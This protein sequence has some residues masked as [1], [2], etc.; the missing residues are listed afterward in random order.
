[1]ILSLIFV[2]RISELLLNS[3]EGQNGQFS[4]TSSGKTPGSIPRSSRILL[5]K[6]HWI[7]RGDVVE[8]GLLLDC[9]PAVHLAVN[10]ADSMSD[11]TGCILAALDY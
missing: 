3:L 2:S 9:G 10:L 11:Q 8:L 5:E 6:I 4:R 1:V 7:R